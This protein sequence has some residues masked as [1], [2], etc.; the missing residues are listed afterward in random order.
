MAVAEGIDLAP[1]SMVYDLGA[2]DGSML[3]ALAERQPN[4]TYIG[5]EIAL[6]P[7]IIGLVRKALGR[8]KRKNVSLRYGDL[9]GK[10]LSGADILFVFLLQKAYPRLAKKFAK[11]LKDEAVVVLEAWP[12]PGVEHERVI[13]ERNEDLPMFVYKGAAFRRAFAGTA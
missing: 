4:A 9:F 2:G 10:D 5:Y 13:R 3:F 8:G 6:P 12:F 11:E 7:W 1:G